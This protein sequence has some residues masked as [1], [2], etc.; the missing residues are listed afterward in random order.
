MN[1][2]Q[3][4]RLRSHLFKGAAGSFV[5]QIGFA[6][7]SF[8]NA[9]ILA[10]VLG[11]EGYGVFANAMAWVSLLTI[12][13]TFGFGILL[14]RDTAI[15]RSQGKWSLLNGLLH[16][17]DR[18]VLVLSVVL[19]FIGAGVSGW[20]FPSP[21]QTMMRQTIWVALLLLPLLAL[22][23]LREATT[24][25]LEYVIHARF[26]GMIVR[27]GLLLLGIGMIYLF[28]PQQLRAPVAMAINVGA[29]V[30]ALGFSV[31]F[32]RNLLPRKVKL[33][34]PKYTPCIWLKTASSMLIY[35][36]AQ[37][38]LGQTDIVMLGAMCDSHEVG[39]YAAA[40]RLAYILMYFTVASELIMAPIMSRL[41]AKGEKGRLRLIVNKAVRLSFL[42]ALPFGIIFIF[43]GD[44][45]LNIFGHDFLQAKNV[46]TILAIGKLISIALGSASLLLGMSGHERTLGK[47]IVSGALINILLNALL[48]PEFGIQGAAIA[49]SVS[50]VSIHILLS[51]C[52]ILKTGVDVS[53]LGFHNCMKKIG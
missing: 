11:A 6:G 10:R 36:G 39:L 15:Y 13:A 34:A 26:P 12:P 1:P 35:G 27:P 28:W 50:L 51:L 5:L 14:V 47:M 2:P 37:V 7:F 44:G 42:I 25:G 4:S 23:N 9:L 29:G 31:F 30:V 33:A 8:L 18:F 24:R 22:A 38:V 17:S 45:I 49:T 46:L 21:A 48:I 53:V 40:N 3:D 43:Y 52:A 19:V 16:F 20:M 32:L 41:Y